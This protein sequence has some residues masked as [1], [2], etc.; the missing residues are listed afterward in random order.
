MEKKQINGEEKGY[1]TNNARIFIRHF[2]GGKTP[3]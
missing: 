2:E 1:L 3:F